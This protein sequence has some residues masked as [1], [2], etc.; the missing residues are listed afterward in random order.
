MSCSA[1]FEFNLFIRRFSLQAEIDSFYESSEDAESLIEKS[2]HL[3]GLQYMNQVINE[4]LRFYPIGAAALSRRCMSDTMVVSG[5]RI[6]EGTH[7]IADMWSIHFDPV[8]WGPIDPEI[9]DPDRFAGAKQRDS[10]NFLAFG[11]GPRHCIGQRFALTEV[12]AVLFRLLRRFS[13]RACATTQVP[14]A[15]RYKPTLAPLNSVDVLLE[16]RSL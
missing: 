10:G 3:S 16:P 7:V 6:P 15:L 1:P 5:H 2:D 9:F 11:I 12:R 4:S 8:S 13:V 14:L